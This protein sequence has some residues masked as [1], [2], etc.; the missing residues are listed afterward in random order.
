MATR[1]SRS[2][3]NVR[4]FGVAHV[5]GAVVVITAGFSAVT[6]QF[7]RDRSA[8]IA[9]ARAWNI[10]G[11]PCPAFT[12]SEFQAR[13]YTAPKIFDYDGIAIGR[14]VGDAYCSDVKDTGGAGLLS[15][16]VCQF[17]TPVAL[18]VASKV[19]TWFYITGVAQPATLI[20]HRGVPRC[21]LASKFTLGHEN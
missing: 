3:R 18:T 7:V 20:I 4:G 17:T 15:D 14:A 5:I 12:Q 8:N 11:A 9:T 2:C 6:F 1:S 16:K 10:Q 21:V 13:R 19:G